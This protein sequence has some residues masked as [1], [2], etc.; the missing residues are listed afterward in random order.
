MMTFIYLDQVEETKLFFEDC[1]RLE[2]VFEPTW[3]RVYK[4][5]KGG[6]LG[7]VDKKKGS[8]SKTYQGGTLVS[9]TVDKV[10]EYYERIKAYGVENL[11]EIK[12]FEDIGVE[13][14]F[15][16]GPGGY[17]FEIQMFT[18]DAIRKLFE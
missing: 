18:K 13:S 11:S 8:L 6:F 17:D 5:S 1:L 12:T 10:S 14:F 2:P 4:V 15:F 7:I 16:N 9:L 3:A